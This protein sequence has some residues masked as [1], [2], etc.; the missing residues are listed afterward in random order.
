MLDFTP[1]QEQQMLIEAIH[2][3]AANDLQPK[4]HEMDETTE[5]P[6]AI[7]H[8]GWEIGLLPASIPESLGGF[9]EYSAV[10]NVL[11]LEELAFGDM[12]VAMKLMAPAL[13]AYP[14]LFE[15]TDDQKGRFL[16]LMAEVEPYPATAALVEPRI[17]F[18]PFELKTTV[19]RQG[20]GSFVLNG[21][22]CYVPN[23]ADAKWLLVYATDTAKQKVGAFLVERESEGVIIGEREKLMGV[24]GLPTYTVKF[25]DVKVTPDLV[26]GG[27]A[28]ANYQNLINHMNIGIAA[29]AVGVMKASHEYAKYY[30]KDRV[31]FG[32][33]IATNQSIAF[34]L[35]E[36]AIEVDSLRLMVWEAAWNMDA[37][38][39]LKE[40]TK[41]AYLVRHYAEQSALHVTDHGVQVL[42]GH[43]FIREHPVER[44]L[45]N[46]RG[47]PMFLGLAI[48]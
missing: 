33:P 13:F 15:G 37:N 23:A 11:A 27:E 40:I 45:R 16:P 4:A 48:A 17:T 24:R 20:D 2:R 31:Q 21:Q 19:T 1:T 39:S 34:M 7:I 26:L 30:A 42:G 29:M 5:I 12:A 8:K 18:D 28:G 25:N 38:K 35:A 46:S 43:G 6:E 41:S 36:S 32:R 47:V 10:T 9:G 22:K 44:W 3:F 14:I